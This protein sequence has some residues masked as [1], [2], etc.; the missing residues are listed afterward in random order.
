MEREKVRM[1]EEERP[2]KRER[3]RNHNDYMYGSAKV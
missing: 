1:G 3:A 2:K